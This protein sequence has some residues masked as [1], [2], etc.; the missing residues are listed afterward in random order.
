MTIKS[1]WG[2]FLIIL[3]EGYIVLS[4]EL[5]AIRQTVP[6]LGSGT[7]T[8]SIII[9][10]VLMPMAFGYHAGG[11]YRTKNP[12]VPIR[13]KLLGN[14]LI[15]SVIVLFALSFPVMDFFF[16]TLEAS[17]IK[18]R[19][20]HATLYSLIFLVVPVYLL[21]QT[22]PLC[23]NYFSRERLADATGRILFFSTIGSFLGAVFSTLVLMNTIGVHNTV[24]VNFVLLST[25][26]L[27]LDKN[28]TSP[29]VLLSLFIL[30][31]AVV[32]NSGMMM[33]R[34]NIVSNN[35]YNTLKVFVEPNGDRVLRINDSFSSMYNDRGGKYHY[36]D[37]VERVTIKTLR[38]NAPVKDVLVLGAGAFTIGI[39][40]RKNQYDY[41]DIDKD[42]LWVAQD[43][44]LKKRLQENHHFHAMP[45][46]AFLI[47]TDK[48]YDLIVHD[49]YGG[50]LT[51]PP[52]LVTH[53][54]YQSVHD[55][56]KPD[57]VF[58]A[59]MIVAAEFSDRASI[60]IDN[61]IRSVFPY[62]SRV[63]MMDHYS[64]WSDQT[65]LANILYVCQST[66]GR[67]V[68]GIYTDDKNTIAF[69]REMPF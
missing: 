34:Y 50:K 33:A 25:L 61:T 14:L 55:H 45:A 19:I 40:D 48:K 43:Y 57:G 7:D 10:A 49:A 51:I 24:T 35:A 5:L 12:G 29:R 60:R 32:L 1:G 6:Y 44:I 63:A 65:P 22:I 64:L 9:A 62:C 20:A 21:A 3:I 67:D 58:I 15:A 39:D 37:F 27:M 46:R 26:V 2:I 47:G 31:V 4:T 59:N 23:S 13:E 11:R 68:S 54:Y 18:G 66:E 53:E 38:P 41:V 56:L 16:K 36:A 28:K 30:L 42:L 17:P 8:V 52:Q 69:D